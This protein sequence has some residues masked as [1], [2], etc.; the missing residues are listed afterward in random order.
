[1]IG[2]ILVRGFTAVAISAVVVTGLNAQQSRFDKA[3]QSGEYSLAIEHANRSDSPDVERLRIAN[4]QLATGSRKAALSVISQIT[5]AEMRSEALSAFGENGSTPTGSGNQ[6]GITEA[7]FD[8]LIDLIQNTIATDTWADTGTGEGTMSAYP[9]GVFVDAS[10]VLKRI[11]KSKRLKL[12]QK[13]L[14]E[15]VEM[16][17]DAD[18]QHASG[19]RVISLTRLERKLQLRVAQ[20]LAPTSEMKYLGGLTELKFVFADP[21]TKEIL[22][23]GE[24]EG[25]TKDRQGRVVGKK[26]GKPVLLLEDLSVCLAN[27]LHGDGKFGCAIVPRQENLAQTREFIETTRLRGKQY[28][29]G[30]RKA[31]GRQDIEVHGIPQNSH[32]AR[33]IVEAD[34]H[35]KLLGMGIESSVEGV[36]SYLDRV[37]PD[38]A[39]NFPPM[40]VARWWFA[41]EYDKLIAN[42]SETLFEFRGPGVRVLAETEFLNKEGQRL[43]TGKAVG[44]TAAFAKDFTQHF[45]KVSEQYPIYRELNNIFDL[46]IVANVI[47]KFELT[48]KAG[49]KLP[50]LSRYSQ[51]DRRPNF[52]EVD[53]VMNSQVLT[54]LKDGQKWRHTIIGVSGGVAFDSSSLVTRESLE[55]EKDREFTSIPAVALEK[56][57]GNVDRWWWDLAGQ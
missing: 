9:T 48:E 46:A 50:F 19:F 16:G 42:E 47:R 7:D 52:K 24:A 12:R 28:Q 14:R 21:E 15:L 22:I 37:Q 8:Q 38:A 41:T 32:A 6:G 43:H 25:W 31:L 53:S 39:G 57:P 26:S 18:A 27:A 34:Y 44:P 11:K 49:Q 56:L 29:K 40:D 54:R 17:G 1:M 36:P 51:P 35:M 5:D 3:L 23:A 2:Q 33:V 4:A 10:G 45:E 30:L 55:L 13:T 20:G